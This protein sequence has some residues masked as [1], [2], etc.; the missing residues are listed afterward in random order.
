MLIVRAWKYDIIPNM[1]ETMTIEQ[2]IQQLQRQLEAK[3][4]ELGQQSSQQ[5]AVPHDKE[6]LREVVKEKIEQHAVQQQAAPAA[7]TVPA[8]A[9]A[10][11]ASAPAY[12]SPE[13][14]SRVQDLVNVAFTQNISDAIRQA[15][16]SKNP[17]L[18]DAFHDVLVDEL[19]GQLLERKKIEPLS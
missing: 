6:I 18:I 19:Y 7:P 15:V 9:P 4:A 10:P 12:M 17:A 1:N 14:Q 8:P 3:K 11:T 16:S 5:E 2:E 13:L